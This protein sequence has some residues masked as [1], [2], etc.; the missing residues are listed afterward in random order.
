MK[1]DY[2]NI[3]PMDSTII[4]AKDLK[5]IS[6]G[7]YFVKDDCTY[8]KGPHSSRKICN[9][10]VRELKFNRNFETVISFT[11]TLRLVDED[12]IYD[13]ENTF[14]ICYYDEPIG[15]LRYGFDPSVFHIHE[16]KPHFN[17][18]LK[19]IFNLICSEEYCGC[20]ESILGWEF[21]TITPNK[22]FLSWSTYDFNKIEDPFD[23]VYQ[24]PDKTTEDN[25]PEEI[26]FE[27]MR[28]ADLKVSVPL[29]SFML[30]AL[31]NSFELLGADTRPGFV[32]AITGKTEELRR[33]TALFFTNLFKRDSTFNKNEYKLFHITQSDTLTDIRFKSEYAKDCVL[34]AFEPDKRHLNYL[35]NNL[36][37]TNVVDEEHPIRSLCLFTADNIDDIK[38]DNII[39]VHLDENFNLEQVIKFFSPEKNKRQKKDKL[40]ESIY[41]YINVL[42]GRL[43]DNGHFI[44]EQFEDYKVFFEA[45][46]RFSNFSDSAYTASVL[47]SFAINMYRYY[48]AVV[49]FPISFEKIDKILIETIKNSFP[50][51]GESTEDDF[52]D[53][54][55]VCTILDDYFYKN[56]DEI[57]KVKQ[58]EY[59]GPVL[60]WYDEKYLYIKGKS[61]TKVLNSSGTKSKFSV[62]VKKSM[63]EK[64]IIESYKKENGQYEYSI[65]LQKQVYDNLKTKGRFVAFN[66]EKCREY[67]LFKKVEEHRIIKETTTIET[68]M[69]NMQN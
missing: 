32:M 53:A 41:Y 14:P 30:L 66:R 45:S 27:Y 69:I 3:E 50:K 60:M 11:V 22:S 47:L 25:I 18:H 37:K 23:S 38:A 52:S 65:N 68:D 51:K 28:L 2:I 36:Y 7:K 8:F 16:Q 35:I 17:L 57:S 62:S 59:S 33:K 55:K 46:H 39:N 6:N 34:I 40:I 54:R 9:F 48:S 12:G 63:A 58:S 44:N 29:M 5:K 56:K 4:H 21:D 61:L 24:P 49:D 43:L 42:I 20:E 64:G 19:E 10:Y 15:W 1:P 26:L 67:D 31:L 13:E